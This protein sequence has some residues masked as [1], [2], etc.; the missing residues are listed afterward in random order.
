MHG[1]RW[2][3]MLGDIH[4]RQTDGSANPS[5]SQRVRRNMEKLRYTIRARLKDARMRC[6]AEMH[7]WVHKR[8]K[9]V[10]EPVRARM[11]AQTRK[12]R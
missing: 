3:M 8:G 11:G 2:H 4:N 9:N 6:T 5:W 1:Y 12:E 7:V 10:K